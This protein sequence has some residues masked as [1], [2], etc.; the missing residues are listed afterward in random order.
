MASH[1]T[2]RRRGLST[3]RRGTKWMVPIVA[4]LVVIGLTITVIDDVPA[5]AAQRG[6][7]T[8]YADRT[9]AGSPK[10]DSQGV[11]LGVKF[12]AAEPGTIAGVRFL[13]A[14]GDKGAHTGS[15]WTAAGQ[16]LASATFRGAVRRGWIDVMFAVPIQVAANT[17]Y[18]ASYYNS[19]GVY[20]IQQEAFAGGAT[21]S[22]SPMLQ[23]TQGR[24]TYGDR[25]VFPS[26]SWND[27]AYYVDV[28]FRPGGSANAAGTGGNS[29]P[30]TVASTTSASVVASP[31]TAPVTS[32]S[33]AAAG[34]GLAVVPLKH[35][36]SSS[37]SVS[38]AAGSS[39][40]L[41]GGYPNASNT[42]VP[43]GTVLS[44]Y[45]GSGGC[46]SGTLTID[47]KTVNS[48]LVVSGTC[49][50]TVTRSLINGQVDSCDGA[51]A[52]CAVSISDSEVNAGN[53][54]GAA[55]GYN[56]LTLVRDN[57]HGGASSVDAAGSVNVRDSWLHGQYLGASASTHNNGLLSNGGSN[58]TAYHDTIACDVN[59][60]NSGGGC[61]GPVALFG[62]F[63]QIN[64]VVFTSNLITATPGGYSATWGCN[65]GKSFPTPSS[66]VATN[67]V[68][69]VQANGNGGYYGTNT[70]WF[71]GNG[72]TW[73]NNTRQDTG[74][75]LPAPTC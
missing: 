35:S 42:G 21:I 26:S 73:S 52:G 45:T 27:S 65:P 7:V 46:S 25:S 38:A 13:T 20:P 67:N 49:R 34:G 75:Q 16:R 5:G 6:Y 32:S 44:A 69:Q 39:S 58:I 11:E 3:S 56:N 47:A 48:D 29:S 55:V 9:K 36:P 68:F 54:S 18:V 17:T 50:L 33:T 8:L 53:N 37:T 23:A 59:D 15:L 12:A 51:G 19:L 22:R 71:V 2:V 31:T 60:N 1:S 61:T 57:I 43:V 28:L 10:T 63:A 74:A 72:D 40:A 70:G 4:G 41:L 64:T 14:F 66:V 30:S 24:Y 62:D